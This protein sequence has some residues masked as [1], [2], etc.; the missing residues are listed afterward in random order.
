MGFSSP[1][2][3]SDDPCLFFR[4]NGGLQSFARTTL[5]N[6]KGMSFDMDQGGDEATA[7]LLSRRIGVRAPESDV[8]DKS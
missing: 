2:S 6:P 3:N 4:F 1:S 8:G 5:P 7:E